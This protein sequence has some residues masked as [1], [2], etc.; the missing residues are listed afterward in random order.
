MEENI[1]EFHEFWVVC[2]CFLAISNIPL[3]STTKFH[4]AVVAD[5][6]ANTSHSSVLMALLNVK[7]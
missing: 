3:I 2:K 1:C 4:V 6:D 7:E 5:N